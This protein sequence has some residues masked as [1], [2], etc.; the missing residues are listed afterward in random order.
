[1]MLRLKRVMMRILLF[2]YIYI[3]QGLGFDGV[4]GKC[5]EADALGDYDI[6]EE[7]SPTMMFP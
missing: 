7:Q 5:F 2:I 3:K 6:S 1:M 4:K